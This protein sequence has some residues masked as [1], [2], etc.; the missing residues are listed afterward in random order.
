MVLAIFQVNDDE[1][2][3]DGIQRVL[4]QTNE[5]FQKVLQYMATPR[6]MAI[7]KKVK[8]RVEHAI[9]YI[10]NIHFEL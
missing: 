8:S 6:L 9:L 5:G 4:S 3:F 7:A 2:L 1:E 10:L